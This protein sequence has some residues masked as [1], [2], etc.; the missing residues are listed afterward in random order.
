MLDLYPKRKDLFIWQLLHV[1]PHL[2]LWGIGALEISKNAIL[3]FGGAD[4]QSESQDVFVFSVQ[5]EEGKESEFELR[6][7]KTQLIEPDWFYHHGVGI[8]DPKDEGMLHILGERKVHVFD[9][10]R[11]EFVKCLVPEETFK[12]DENSV[13]DENDN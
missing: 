8:R 4:R 7:L 1:H 6:R 13:E 2:Q 9:L 5:E 10:K 12:R 3:L 11:F